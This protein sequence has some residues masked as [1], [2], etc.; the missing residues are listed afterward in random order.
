MSARAAERLRES[1][2]AEKNSHR[3][4]GTQISFLRLVMDRVEVGRWIVNPVDM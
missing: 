3:F 4:N 2:R 1:P